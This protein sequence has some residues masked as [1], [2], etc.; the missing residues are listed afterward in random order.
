MSTVDLPAHVE[1]R[2]QSTVDGLIDSRQCR[3]SG[4]GLLQQ[5]EDFGDP[6]GGTDMIELFQGLV[7]FAEAR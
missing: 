3:L 6:K 4:T 7:D 1:C 2:R 5:K